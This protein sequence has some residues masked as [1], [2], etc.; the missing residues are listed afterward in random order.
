MNTSAISS[1]PQKREFT[2]QLAWTAFILLFFII[3]AILWTVAIS[4]TSQDSSHAVVS[5]YDQQALHWDEV[6]RRRSASNKLGWKATAS[7]GGSTDVADIRVVS[8]Q[9]LNAQDQAVSDAQ[10]EVKV[11]HRGHAAD[12]HVMKFT[13]QGDGVY[14]SKMPVCHDGW[15]VFDGTAKVDDAEYLID[16]TIQFKR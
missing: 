11:F 15:W 1:Q 9:I 14:Q 8:V 3:Q 6:K 13:C 2:A 7:F 16:T 10:V 5:G 12:V 4:A